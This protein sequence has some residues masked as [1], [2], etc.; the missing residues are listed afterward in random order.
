[1]VATDVGGTCTDTIVFA[2]GEPVHLGKTLSTP[3]DF[4]IGVMDSIRSATESMGISLAELLANTSLF[5][6]GSTVVD[7]TILTRDGA[8]T[9]LITT[10]GFEDTV[11]TTRGAYG[12]WGGLSEDRIKHP[13]KTER[14]PPL[15]DPDCIVGVA[16]RTDYKGAVLQELDEAVAES[17]I[18]FLLAEKSVEAL[19]VSFLWSFYN[20][21]NERKVKK[22]V[23]RIAPSVYC[24]LSS[25]IAP[26]PGEYERSSTTVINA[27]AGRITSNYL[28]N[29]QSL[30]EQAGYRGPVMVMQG[31]GGLLPAREAAD[32]SIG[33][34]ECGPAAGVIGSRVLGE[35]LGQPDVI[36]TDMG[37]TTFKVSVIQNG[38]IEYA[39]EPM[40][41]RF[42]Y[43]QPKIEVVSIGAAGGSV[44][45]LEEGTRIPRVGPRSAGARPGPVCYGLGG[46][47]PTLTDVF[48]LI[49]YMDPN[50][51]LGGTMQLDP[52]NAR[53]VFDE[54]IATPLRM[55]VE[56]AAFGIYRVA[57]AQISDLIHEITVERGLD[58]RDFVLHAFGGSCGIVAGMFGAELNVK[59]M[60]IP[61]TASVNCAFGLVSADIVHEYSR[62]MVL[63]VPS[64]A[65]AINEIYRPMIEQARRQLKEEGFTGEKV[66]LEWSI[67]LRYSRQVHEVT[68]TVRGRTPVDEG[69]LAQLVLDF[70]AQY[71]RKYGKGSA[72]REAGIELTLFRLTARG[73]IDRPR[74][75]PLPLVG[76]DASHAKIGRRSI[77]VDAKNG[78]AEADIYAFGKL[79]PGNMV[80]G[81]AV[82]HTPIT[83]IVLQAGQRGTVDGFRNVVVDFD[84]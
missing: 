24:T 18:R 53:S 46:T 78:M 42:H 23:E 43:T 3:S 62:T 10:R 73:L 28:R 76:T 60:V 11:L 39:R 27:Y 81:P 15:V 75:E 7:N 72:F 1:M 66:K 40:V 44:V 32:R 79:A 65:E 5:M 14:T 26:I 74:L 80:Q 49:G 51:F 71:E 36:A 45:W 29:L 33:M 64:P 16:E 41:D 22:L 48:M 8:R 55:G 4:S 12:R 13:V 84:A 58:P 54:K 31:Y 6:H 19:A 82:I 17:A 37:G 47:E 52:A 9:G 2:A 34:L 35:L 21:D 57:T 50:I 56:E 68:T 38:E 25:E 69:A 63:Q 59:Q 20:A 77:F 67:D 61:Y 83:T 30:L 70:E